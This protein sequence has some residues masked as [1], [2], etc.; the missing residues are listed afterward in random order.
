MSAPRADKPRRIQLRRTKGWRK[1]PNT[2]VVSRPSKWGNPYPVSVWGRETSLLLYRD[3]VE[4]EV[5]AGRLDL[6]ELHNK[7]LACWC[8]LELSCHVDILFE[9]IAARW[10]A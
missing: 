9:L 3:W 7:N 5:A 8:G 1:P 2:V 4:E 6:A 10:A